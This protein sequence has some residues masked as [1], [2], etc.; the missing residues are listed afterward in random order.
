MIAG[1]ISIEMGFASRE[2]VCGCSSRW[3]LPEQEALVLVTQG[4]KME[5]CNSSG[6]LR[7]QPE[8]DT[9]TH[10]QRAKTLQERAVGVK[11]YV[12]TT[13]SDSAPGTA[14]APLRTLAGAQ[15]AIRKRYPTVSARPAIT[16][17]IAP[18]LSLS[19]SLSVSLSQSH[20]CVHVCAA[21]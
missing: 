3:T 10:A 18:G 4:L 16:V 8:T 2:V 14:A 19:L 21:G 7:T 9:Q 6:L 12:A 20:L 17:L 11:L 5:D 15:A 1:E 13:G